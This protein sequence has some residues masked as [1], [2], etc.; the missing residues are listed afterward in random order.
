MCLFILAV[1][2][3][4]CWCELLFWCAIQQ[5]QAR[6]FSLAQPHFSVA[7]VMLLLPPAGPVA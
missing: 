1:A 2:M 7:V 5:A 4:S 3:D 6:V